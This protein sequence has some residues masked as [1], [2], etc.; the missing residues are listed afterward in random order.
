MNWFLYD[1]GPRHKELMNIARIISGN[2]VAHINELNLVTDSVD[3]TIKLF[4]LLHICNNRVSCFINL[5]H[6]FVL[7]PGVF[8][9]LLFYQKNIRNFIRDFIRTETLLEQN[10][11]TATYSR[12]SNRR[13]GWQISAKMINGEGAINGEVGKNLQG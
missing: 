1:N 6:D 5:Q 12:V 9:A 13:R 4:P 2:I 7:L 11:E 10:P 3:A 8:E